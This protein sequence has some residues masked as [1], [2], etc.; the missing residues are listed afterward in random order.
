MRR[1]AYP[2]EDPDSLPPPSLIAVEIA[3]FVGGLFE[4]GG[5]EI[6]GAVLAMTDIV[7]MKSSGRGHDGF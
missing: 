1:F 2:L 4:S 5:R 6:N 7:K 3:R